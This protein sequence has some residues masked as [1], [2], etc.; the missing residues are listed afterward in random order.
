MG[1][2]LKVLV[3]ADNPEDVRLLQELFGKTSSLQC[4]L[5]QIAQLDEALQGLAVG[6]IDIVL[7]G[8]SLSAQGLDTVSQLVTAAPDV[9]II[10]LGA[11][12][13]DTLA[14]EA[15]QRGAQDY[16]VKSQWEDV[17]MLARA[18]R[19]AI[20]RNRMRI[21][22]RSLSLTDELT[23]L[24]NRR[25]FLTLANQQLKLA[26]RAKQPLLFLFVDLDGLKQINDTF[27]HQEGDRAL[28]KTAEILRATLRQS[29]IIARIGGDEF[30]A[31]AIGAPEGSAL[32]ISARLQEQLSHYNTHNALPYK[33]S[34]SLGVATLDPHKTTSVDELIATADRALYEHKRSKQTV[35]NT[36][37]N[38]TQAHE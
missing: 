11:I 9:P 6:G 31:L 32:L 29:D 14:V 30:T 35:A 20:E 17:L 27:G 10:V 13:D 7:L 21:E 24:Y 38:S 34:F 36:E 22:L 8:L 5:V 19:Y 33:L 3:V 1:A 26:Y 12:D 18:M 25:G 4:D 2:R 15:M 28:I 23:G 16:L 37:R